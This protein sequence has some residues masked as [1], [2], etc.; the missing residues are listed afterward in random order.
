M[1][2]FEKAVHYI[3]DLAD[4]GELKAAEQLPSIRDLAERLHISK[5]SVIR[6]YEELES[7]HLVYVI[8]KSGYYWMDRLLEATPKRFGVD[9]TKVHPDE[10]LIPF[11]AFQHCMNQSI[12]LYQKELFGYSDPAGLPR[13]VSA[14]LRHLAD[15]QIYCRPNQIAITSGSQQALAILARMDFGNGANTILVEQPSYSVFQQLSELEAIPMCGFPRSPE[16]LDLKALE[17]AFKTGLYKCF[18]C[19]PRCHNPY[20]TSLSDKEKKKLVALANKYK[21]YIIEDDYLADLSTDHKQMPL[22][23]YDTAGMVI[24]VKSFSKAFLPGIRLGFAVLPQNLHPLFLK[25]KKAHDLSTSVFSQGA[26]ELFISSGLYDKH[27]Q[28]IQKLYRHKGDV[29]AGILSSLLPLKPFGVHVILP[30][31]GFI[32]WIGFDASFDLN[33]LYKA[34]QFEGIKVSDASEFNILS[35]NQLNGF[36]LC[37]APLNEEELTTGLMRLV[38]LILERIPSH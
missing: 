37:L 31:S 14:L 11:R 4:R 6:G 13:L 34:L 28:K 2:Q 18:Y 22:Y 23:Y 21:V 20:G 25:H 19:I 1:K 15:R 12:E 8:P 9:F 38:A 32:C 17:K 3:L 27:T 36:R 29:A 35:P 24:Y 30:E 10:K 5:A 16:G 26:L 7:R 33:D